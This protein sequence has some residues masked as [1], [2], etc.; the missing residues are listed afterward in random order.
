M[1]VKTIGSIFLNPKMRYKVAE[2]LNK[3]GI[4]I[5]EES[6]PNFVVIKYNDDRITIDSAGC[7]VHNPVPK[8]WF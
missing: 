4:I 8:V 6:S 2:Y 1:M 5:D 7:V 3:G